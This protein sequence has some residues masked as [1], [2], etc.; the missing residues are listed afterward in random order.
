ML[1][2]EKIS[3]KKVSNFKTND[4]E[5]DDDGKLR[6]DKFLWAARFYKTRA[7]ATEEI[8]KGRV[9]INGALVKAS[10]EVR[11]GDELEILQPPFTRR[12]VVK[13]LSH[14]RGSASVAQAWVEETPSSLAARLALLEHSRLNPEPALSITQGRPTKRDRRTLD[15]A[16]SGGAA[17]DWNAR[18]SAS[19]D[20]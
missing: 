13:A 18:W 7:L 1:T 14:Q 6:I 15:N 4:S 17:P 8:G 9:K 2:H 5:N 3:M 10:R 16:R 20:D 11:V 12:V 19:I